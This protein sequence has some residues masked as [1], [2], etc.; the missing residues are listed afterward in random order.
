MKQN[1]MKL[2]EFMKRCPLGGYCFNPIC[3]IGGCQ[4]SKSNHSR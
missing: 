1:W 2:A 4:E 3:M